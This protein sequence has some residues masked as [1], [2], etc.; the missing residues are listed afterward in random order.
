MLSFAVSRF[1]LCIILWHVIP[2]ICGWWTV[3][4]LGP[5]KSCRRSWKWEGWY[6]CK[7]WPFSL[8]YCTKIITFWT[9]TTYNEV[10]IWKM[11]KIVEQLYS[12]QT[13]VRSLSHRDA[14]IIHRLRIG[15]TRLTHSYLLSGTDQPECSAHWRSS[16]FWLNA[17][18][19][20]AVV[21]NIL[22]LLQ[23]ITFLIT[24]LPETLSIL[25]RNPIFYGT[26]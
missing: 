1:F 15:H 7:R 20:L 10:D 23:W 11:A 25:S 8:C 13:S 26:V 2:T 12:Q 17:L 16:T 4:C 6:C 14:V 18:H 5:F 24:V 19:W 21:T 3:F 9:T 22:L